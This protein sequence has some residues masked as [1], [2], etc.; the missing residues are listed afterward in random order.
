MKDKSNKTSIQRCGLCRTVSNGICND[1]RKWKE[2][3]IKN[4]LCACNLCYDTQQYQQAVVRLCS[5]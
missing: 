4:N 2:L 3:R 5:A 1:C